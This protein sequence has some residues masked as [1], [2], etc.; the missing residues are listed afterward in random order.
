MTWRPA[1]CQILE[2]KLLGPQYDTSIHKCDKHQTPDAKSRQTI[3]YLILQRKYIQEDIKKY[4]I[5]PY[6]EQTKQYSAKKQQ[7]EIQNNYRDAHLMKSKPT[8]NT[9]SQQFKTAGETNK[10]IKQLQRKPRA[11][12]NQTHPKTTQKQ[13][14]ATQP[15]LKNN[16]E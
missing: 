12:T 16:T 9:S 4:Q 6:G 7:P 13:E 5:I 15:E 3:Q 2:R 10:T 1:T 14:N 8:D 11:K